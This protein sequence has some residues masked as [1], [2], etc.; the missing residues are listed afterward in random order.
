MSMACIRAFLLFVS[1]LG[2]TVAIQDFKH[3]SQFLEWCSQYFKGQTDEQLAEIYP[4][5]REN[6]DFVQHHNSLRLS[7]TLSM[8]HFGH[9]VIILLASYD[10]I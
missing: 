7:Y 4:T 6:A 2:V 3:D 5:W 1:I 10:T 9:L 8:N